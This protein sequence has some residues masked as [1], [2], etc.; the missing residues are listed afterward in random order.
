MMKQAKT[1]VDPA[2]NRKPQARRLRAIA[3]VCG[4]ASG[5]TPARGVRLHAAPVTDSRGVCA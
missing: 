2:P 5:M 1:R 3:L 4:I